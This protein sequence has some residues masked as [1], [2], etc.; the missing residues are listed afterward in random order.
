MRKPI[1]HLGGK[2]KSVHHFLKLIPY[3]NKYIEVFGGGA[4]LLFAKKRSYKEVYNDVD[5]LLVNF[6]IV[7]RD[8]HQAFFKFLNRTPIS[9]EI[10]KEY[11]GHW[12]EGLLVLPDKLK[13]LEPI[14]RAAIYFFIKR[15]SYGN[16]MCIFDGVNRTSSN[17]RISAR[18]VVSF[19]RRLK[20]VIIESRGYENVIEKYDSPDSFFYCD[21]PYY[22][23]Y[24]GKWYGTKWT[25]KEH[26]R[27]RDMLKNIKGKVMLSYGSHAFIRDL[28]KSFDIKEIKTCYSITH[29]KDDDSNKIV[30]DLIIKNY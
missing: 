13:K 29:V 27:L 9:T 10:F 25:G 7:L 3:H 17:Y 14:E 24:G 18:D 8:K 30:T 22:N 1:G 20:D 4:S 6:F 21:P 12:K 28:Y 15:N 11:C 26:L 5:N 19:S 2:D 16:K 23:D